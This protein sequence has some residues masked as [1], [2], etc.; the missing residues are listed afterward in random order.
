MPTLLKRRNISRSPVVKNQ[1]NFLETS[2]K[3][4]KQK[5]PYTVM[6]IVIDDVVLDTSKQE[7][8]LNNI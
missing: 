8:D 4:M 6:K 5:F 1:L 3:L 2:S 7:Y